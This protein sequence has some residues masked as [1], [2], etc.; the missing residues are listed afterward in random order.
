MNDLRKLTRIILAAL[1]LYMLINASFSLFL[2]LPF[3]LFADSSSVNALAILQPL[4]PIGFAVVLL[5]VL[6]FRADWW[7]ERIVGQEEPARAGV[8][9]LPAA[10]RLACVFS[11]IFYVYRVI[12]TII[13]TAHAYLV[14]QRESPH[15]I[16]PT[17][18][19]N[20]ILAW[21]ILLAL[22]LYLLYGAPHFVRWQVRKTLEQCSKPQR[23]TEES[24]EL[25]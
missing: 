12:P 23:G 6:F 10:F 4:F 25:P 24:T 17:I 7:I 8:W 18:T 3:L 9:W 15:A 16:L 11:G 19:G 14:T 13:S 1:A 22:G 20:Q 21:I 5:Y 2:L